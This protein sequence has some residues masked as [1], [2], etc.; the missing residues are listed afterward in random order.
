MVLP[1]TVEH[2]PPEEMLKTETP[3]MSHPTAFEDAF[4]QAMEQTLSQFPTNTTPQTTDE[5]MAQEMVIEDNYI[6][7]MDQIP[8]SFTRIPMYHFLC[9]INGKP[10]RAFV[11]TGASVSIMTWDCAKRVGLDH[12]VDTKTRIQC[13]GVGSQV[14][15]GRIW[16]ANLEIGEFE[17]PCGFTVMERMTGF[18][19]IFGLDMLARHGCKIDCTGRKLELSDVGVLDLVSLEEVDKM[20][21]KLIS[22]GTLEDDL[23]MAEALENSC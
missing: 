11:D 4:R 15:V 16:L 9:K 22:Q 1:I 19:I 23:A 10:I 21:A 8:A 18:D 5:L 13:V 7:A 2:T 6:Q 12:L 3:T 14:S 17:I 20:Y